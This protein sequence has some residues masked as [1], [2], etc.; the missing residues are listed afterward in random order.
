M[1][2]EPGNVSASAV[3]ALSLRLARIGC[4]KNQTRRSGPRHAYQ[5]FLGSGIVGDTVKEIISGIKV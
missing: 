1:G 2:G 3:W 4:K 5:D